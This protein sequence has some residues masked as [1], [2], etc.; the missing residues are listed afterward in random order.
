VT[1]KSLVHCLNEKNELNDVV[2]DNCC[3]ND[4][5]D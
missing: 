3:E 1:L 4:L 2:I 5:R